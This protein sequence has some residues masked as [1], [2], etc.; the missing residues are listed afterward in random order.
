M[1]TASPAQTIERLVDAGLVEPRGNTRGRS[2]TLSAKVYRARNDKAAY[3]RQAGFDAL[4]QEQMVV[5]Y[6]KNHGSLRRSDVV[7]LCRITPRQATR[8]L[9]KLVA[10]EQLVRK[11][12]RRAA[13]YEPPPGSYAPPRARKSRKKSP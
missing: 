12:T 10:E 3:V 13:L 6:A 4:Q 8:L 1:R 11:G 5:T 2:Y 9:S 7:E